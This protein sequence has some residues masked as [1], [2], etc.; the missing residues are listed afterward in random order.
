MTEGM[1]PTLVQQQQLSRYNA[2]R[3]IVLIVVF[4]ALFSFFLV[5]VFGQGSFWERFSLMMA[6]FF[7]YTGVLSAFLLPGTIAT[8]EVGDKS[9]FVSRVNTATSQLGYSSATQMEDFYIYEPSAWW[10]VAMFAW[11]LSV[12][13]HD[14][15]AVIVGPKRTVGSLL[16][17]IGEA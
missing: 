12:R 10:K 6:F 17:R 4:I 11:P 3:Q 2:L 5:A 9:A 13:L 1:P 14:T 7:I 16:K 8:L 15:Q